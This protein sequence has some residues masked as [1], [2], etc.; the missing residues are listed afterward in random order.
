MPTTLRILQITPIAQYLAS[1]AIDK[2]QLF[3]NKNLSPN[4]PVWIYGI[5]KILKKI[6]D[7]DPAYTGIDQVAKYLYEFIQPFALQAGAIFDG[8]TGGIVPSPTP[9]QQFPIYIT[10]ANFT[11]ATF[12]P[13]ANIFGNNV[14]IFLNEINR[15]LIP[16]SEFTVDAT[17]ITITLGGFDASIN[18]YNLVIEKYSS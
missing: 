17:G 14:I 3:G 4:L 8:N 2:N 18:T 6:Y 15:Y 1:N 7:I 5:Y 13:N 9:T 12:Y 11:T 10:Q 16:G